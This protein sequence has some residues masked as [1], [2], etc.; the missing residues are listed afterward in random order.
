MKDTCT[1]TFIAALLPTAKTWRQPVLSDGGADKEDGTHVH[2]HTHVH[3]CTHRR[4]HTNLY[5]HDDIS[6]P[7]VSVNKE[8]ERGEK[9][10]EGR[11]ISSIF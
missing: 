6:T 11:T 10:R 9:G 2:T 5:T 3:T 8:R 1:S 7:T 4:T